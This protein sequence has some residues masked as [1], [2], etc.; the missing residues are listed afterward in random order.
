MFTPDG[1]SLLSPVGNR[2]SVFDLVKCVHYLFTCTPS[3]NPEATNLERCP[4]RTEKTF[5]ELPSLPMPASSSQSTRMV[6]LFSSTLSAASCC[7][8]STSRN[9]SMISTFRQMESQ[10]IRDFFSRGRTD[11]RHRRYIAVTHDSHIQVWR[12]PNHLVREF[13]PFVLHRTY[14]G[15]HDEVLSIRW[16]SD[17]K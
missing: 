15:H 11:A 9:P 5:R 8:I 16:S 7:T 10:F 3:D 1:N 13:A 17:S 2:V 12:T 14:T 6:V 4:S